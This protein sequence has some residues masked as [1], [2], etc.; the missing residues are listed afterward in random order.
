MTN[1]VPKVLNSETHKMF[2]P[3]VNG[4]KMQINTSGTASAFCV[5]FCDYKNE[6]VILPTHPVRQGLTL[7]S[8]E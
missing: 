6:L 4:K 3:K 8:H 2:Q 7:G 5:V 1:N